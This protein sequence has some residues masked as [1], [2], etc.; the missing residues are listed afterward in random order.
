MHSIATTSC[1]SALHLAVVAL[2]LHA[3]EEVIVPA[4]TWVST[5][6]IVDDQHARP[7]FCDIDLETFNIDVSAIEAAITPRTVGIIPVHLFGLSADMAPVSTSR[8]VAV[9]G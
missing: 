3:G 6:N 5:A 2:G 7:V 1:T 9:Y 8:V 4:F